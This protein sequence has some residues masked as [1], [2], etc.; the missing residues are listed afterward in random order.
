MTAFYYIL[1]HHIQAGCQG[2]YYVVCLSDLTAQVV[3]VSLSRLALCVTDY[4][5]LRRQLDSHA[6]LRLALVAAPDPDDMAASDD[7]LERICQQL[8]TPEEMSELRGK[9][10]GKMESIGARA[11]NVASMGVARQNQLVLVGDMLIRA[12]TRK[13]KAGEPDE[14][15][16]LQLLAAKS[17]YLRNE[18]LACRTRG[19]PFQH[20][21]CQN[22]AEGIATASRLGK[23]D[24]AKQLLSVA[25]AGLREAGASYADAQQYFTR[26]VE[27]S[28]GQHV[29]VIKGRSR[30]YARAVVVQMEEGGSVLV[31]VME[32]PKAMG[33]ADGEGGQENEDDEEGSWS[34]SEESTEEQGEGLYTE[35]VARAQV[36]AVMD[37]RIDHHRIA[38]AVKHAKEH[39]PGAQVRIISASDINALDSTFVAL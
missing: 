32:E 18:L 3:G 22:L 15:G 16:V 37:V 4:A 24:T 21:V 38:A 10:P 13:L 14:S 29:K 2:H 20:V 27:L 6:T 28:P 9:V 39:H 1:G 26:L 35:I 25:V 23:L 8:L 31:N 36:I 17:T 11:P 33:G 12:V 5:E 7:G 30:K 34:A 19:E